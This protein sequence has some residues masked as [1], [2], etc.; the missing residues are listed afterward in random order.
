MNWEALGAVGELVGAAGV[1]LTLAYLAIQI[2]Q[3]TL[4]VRGSMNDAVAG[5]FREI[6]QL[7]IG[8]SDLT[9]IWTRGIENPDSLDSDERM[10]LVHLVFLMFQAFSNMH[11][12]YCAGTLDE[13]QWQGWKILLS[14]YV[15]APGMAACWRERSTI[16]PQGFRE[17]VESLDSSDPKRVAQVADA[18]ALGSS[19]AA[20]PTKP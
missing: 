4:A 18:L 3:N 8:D 13:S 15:A 12:Q 19:P 17:L 20:T 10:R 16:F 1:I 11:F 7:I 14:D 5:Q 2:R 6:K 9:R